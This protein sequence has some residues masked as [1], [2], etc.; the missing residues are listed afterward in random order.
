M[1]YANSMSDREDEEDE[2]SRPKEQ[3][4]DD[5]HAAQ[6]SEKRADK[7]PD[8]EMRMDSPV[9]RTR[10]EVGPGI[11]TGQEDGRCIN[12][13]EDSDADPQK[14]QARSQ[15]ISRGIAIRIAG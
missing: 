6:A 2:N 13:K 15:R 4:E 3:A 9:A 12:Q 10:A 7:S 11:R 5:Q 1:F 8:L 14:E